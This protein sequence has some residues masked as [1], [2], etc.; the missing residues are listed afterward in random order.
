MNS[1]EQTYNLERRV[2]LLEDKIDVLNEKIDKLIRLWE[3]AN[4]LILFIKW[5]GWAAGGIG[6]IFTFYKIGGRP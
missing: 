5:I 4:T 1:E 2:S 6:A 3:A